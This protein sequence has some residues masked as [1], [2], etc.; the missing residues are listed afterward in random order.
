[1]KIIKIL[2]TGCPN[3]KRTEAVVKTVV[4]ELNIDA[5]I[6]KVEDIQDIMAYNIMSTPAVVI[7]EEIKIKGRVP[8]FDEVKT[9][10]QEDDSCCSDTDDSCC[11]PK[12]EDTTSGSCCC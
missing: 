7:N 6:I 4:E 2:G 9:L 1:M 5:K 10:L 12:E 8:S 3:C 11:E